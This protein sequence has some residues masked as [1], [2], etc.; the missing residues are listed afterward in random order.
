ML[1]ERVVTGEALGGGRVRIGDAVMEVPGV[2]AVA[3]AVVR[4]S[5]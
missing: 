1:P 4:L 2:D 3:G 5:W